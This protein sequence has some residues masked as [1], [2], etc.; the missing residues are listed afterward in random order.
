MQKKQSKKIFLLYNIFF[1]TYLLLTPQKN[2]AQKALLQAGPMIGYAEMRE[3]ALWVQ[4]RET[5]QVQFKYWEQK[6]NT[7]TPTDTLYTNLITTQKQN[8]FCTTLIADKVEPSK[9]YEY[10][11]FI[12]NQKIQF[13]YPLQFQTPALWQFR[14]DP[15]NFSLAVGSC[16]FINEEKYDRPKPYGSN[17]QIFETINNQKP[18][19]MLW[20]GDNTYLR[21]PDFFSLTGIQYRYTHTRSIP[22]LQP[23]LAR[24][25]HYAIYDDHD[26]GPNDADRSFIHKDLTVNTFKTFWANPPSFLQNQ[27]GGITTSFQWADV[28]FFMLDNRYFRSPNRRKTY[29]ECTVL[30]KEQLQWLIDALS[31]SYATFKLV[32][33]G[34]QFLNPANVF[35][36]YNNICP[37][38]RQYI[39]DEIYKNNIKGVVFLTGDRH[40]TELSQLKA[41]ELPTIY[42]LTV[43]PFTS[44]T[45]AANIGEN[46]LQVPNTLVNEHN[47]AILNFSGT[48]KD[49]NMEIKIFS[50]NGKLIWTK[51]IKANDEWPYKK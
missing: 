39:I 31:G 18:D 6:S 3:V 17:T 29:N 33:I 37:T 24:T 7:T 8:A 11:L 9:K 23:L 42:D 41:E 4:T 5:A 2:F 34:G 1:I 40:H 51:T 38:E 36:T 32:A 13:S 22:Q 27:N 30:G 49:R 44:G 26:Y 47:F 45:H 46:A 43:S 19:L 20:L 10:Q 48:R 12:N 14:T 28:E 25:H 35:E 15:P 16:N 50:A 21:E